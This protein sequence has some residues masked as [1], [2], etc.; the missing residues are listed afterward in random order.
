MNRLK[1]S[2]SKD[3][4]P[5]LD[6]V[7]KLNGLL[8]NFLRNESF[9]SHPTDSK[10]ILSSRK[11]QSRTKS[12]YTILKDGL[13]CSGHVHPCAITVSWNDLMEKEAPSVVLVIG[14]PPASRE[15]KWEVQTEVEHDPMESRET[16]MLAQVH[17]LH[18]QLQLQ[19]RKEMLAK[20]ADSH[21]AGIAAV[22]VAATAVNPASPARSSEKLWL[23][24]IPKKLKKKFK[25]KTPPKPSASPPSSLPMTKDPE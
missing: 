25:K 6:K 11:L 4:K 24:R 1:V 20:A 10:Q 13:K 12:L 16:Q 22:A 9:I 8:S 7:S 17:D 21:K 19:K 2:F 18:K 15:I 3:K 14:D 23:R 5:L